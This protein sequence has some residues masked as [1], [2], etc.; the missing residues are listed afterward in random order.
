MKRISEDEAYVVRSLIAELK[1]FVAISGQ[2]DAEYPE[3]DDE[4]DVDYEHVKSK[5]KQA[6]NLMIEMFDENDRFSAIKSI[7]EW[8]L[9]DLTQDNKPK[10]MTKEEMKEKRAERAAKKSKSA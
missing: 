5:F 7:L 4:K 2:K 6:E 8:C 3:F 1:T 10:L 9:Y